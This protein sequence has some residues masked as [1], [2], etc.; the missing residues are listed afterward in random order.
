MTAWGTCSEVLDLRNAV[1]TLK[2]AK[3]SILEA[4]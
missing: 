2:A 4:A 3:G 1:G